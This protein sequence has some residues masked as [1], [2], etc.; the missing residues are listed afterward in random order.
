[1]V[2]IQRWTKEIKLRQHHSETSKKWN[3]P[4]SCD[5]IFKYGKGLHVYDS[6]KRTHEENPFALLQLHHFS[7]VPELKM[8]KYF[9]VNISPLVD[10]NTDPFGQCW[11]KVGMNNIVRNENDPTVDG[12][13]VAPTAPHTLSFLFSGFLFIWVRTTTCIPALMH[14]IPS[15]SW[16]FCNNIS[17]LII[18]CS[19]FIFF[20]FGF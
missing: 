19:N 20:L 5:L 15:Y 8:Q 16:C 10:W 7:I 12:I 13:D 18:N 2:T 11:E 1:M 14:R 4:K 3:F 17:N 9:E 6:H